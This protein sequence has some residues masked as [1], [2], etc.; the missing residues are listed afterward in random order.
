MQNV[1]AGVSGMN[2][3]SISLPSARRSRNF[4]VPSMDRSRLTDLGGRQ[5]EAGGERGA[6]RLRQIGHGLERG[7]PVAIHPPKNLASAETFLAALLEH[8]L[9][10]VD[11]RARPD[12]APVKPRPVSVSFPMV[13]RFPILSRNDSRSSSRLS[14]LART[15]R[16]C[17]SVLRTGNSFSVKALRHVASP[18]EHAFLLRASP[19][20]IHRSSETFSITASV[21]SPS[22]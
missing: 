9:E 14:A 22:G 20:R 19:C 5:R 2:T 12:R 15:G 7:D 10:S 11:A 3:D 6:K 13:C 21:F 18:R 1:I 16:P 17:Y 4:S 8:R